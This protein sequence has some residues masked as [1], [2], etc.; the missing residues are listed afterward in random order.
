MSADGSAV[1]GPAPASEPV[2]A[3]DPSALAA[4]EAARRAHPS[5]RR[6]AA[7]VGHVRPAPQRRPES[8]L[9][10]VPRREEAA[11]RL[12]AAQDHRQVRPAR[13]AAAVVV[14]RD[15]EDGPELLLRHRP[16]Q[17]PLGVVGL[18]GG[19]L[20]EEDADPCTWYGPAPRDWAQRLGLSDLRRSRQHVVAAVRELFEETGLLL[21]G[22]REGDV[23]LDPATPLWEEARTSLEAEGFGL[24]AQLQRRGL[25][26]RTDLLRP[27]GRW[28]SPDF[29]HRRFDAVVFAAAVP[30]GQQAT[31]RPAEGTSR[32]T[33][34]LLAWVP[35]ARLFTGPLALPGPPGWLGES[36]VVE[37]CEVMAPPT[38]MIARSLADA[39]SAVAFL[40]GCA[41]GA[42][43]RPIQTWRMAPAGDDGD[44]LWL[45]PTAD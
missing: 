32:E 18:P 22:E 38:L 25:G 16:G 30:P 5:Q 3:L 21:A 1:P 6:P 17:T 45:R 34:G 12:W 40:L 26:L 10:P 39:G 20:T 27:V 15:G 13:R 28:I 33:A 35:A 44:R 2:P 37:A 4:R 8:T 42:A 23:V 7:P 14:V 31:V 43:D 41:D 11:A 24:P 9:I 19:S 36:G 29:R